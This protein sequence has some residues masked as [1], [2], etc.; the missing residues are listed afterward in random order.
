MI[1]TMSFKQKKLRQGW[2]ASV[3]SLCSSGVGKRIDVF[4]GLVLELPS[5]RP[6][7]PR[8]TLLPFTWGN[9]IANTLSNVGSRTELAQISFEFRI[10]S[11]APVP[12][13]YCCAWNQEP[14]FLLMTLSFHS[15]SSIPE[16][17]TGPRGKL[18]ENTEFPLP[19]CNGFGLLSADDFPLQRAGMKLSCSK[20]SSSLVFR[21]SRD[22]TSLTCHMPCFFPYFASGFQLWQTCLCLFLLCLTMP[23]DVFVF[24]LGKCLSLRDLWRAYALN[25]L[26]C[27]VR[28][29]AVFHYL[30]KEQIWAAH[31]PGTAIL[32]PAR[33]WF[34]SGEAK[35]S[36]NKV[37]LSRQMMTGPAWADTW[38]RETDIHLS[39]QGVWLGWLRGSQ[40]SGVPGH[41][42]VCLQFCFFGKG[43]EWVLSQA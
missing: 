12:L 6:D 36:S 19:M 22:K 15:S 42:L 29:K 35:E 33:W 26:L 2:E 21:P 11:C 41:S 23:S 9:G 40:W 24:N 38:N 34:L 7:L 17:T 25:W 32:V 8:L 1:N 30:S 31:Q 27:M 20:A 28:R 43:D 13:P 39:R 4:V 10:L 5:S 3:T 14:W 18:S 37:L 16:L